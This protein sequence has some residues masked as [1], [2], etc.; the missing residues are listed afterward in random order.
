MG[1]RDAPRVVEE[2]E[3]CGCR[4][5]DIAGAGIESAAIIFRFETLDTL[6]RSHLQNAESISRMICESAA[7]Q[8]RGQHRRH[9]EGAHLQYSGNRILKSVSRILSVKNSGC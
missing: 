7:G 3:A 1:M 8:Q 6:C 5:R 4:L 9:G 2:G